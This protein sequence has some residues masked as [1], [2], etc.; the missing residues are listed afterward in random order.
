MKQLRGVDPLMYL[1]ALGLLVRNPAIMVV[2]LLMGVIGVFVSQFA[3]DPGGGM[4][5][6]LTGSITGFII[7]LLKLFAFGTATILADQAW[8]RPRVSFD[9]GWT[10]ARRKAGEIISAAFGFTFVLFIAGYAAQLLGPFGLV[11]Y[12]AAIFFL[13]YT[14]PAAAI[15]GVPGGAALQISIDRARAHPIP[16]IVVTVISVA[17]FLY[18]GVLLSPLLA[19]F[20]TPLSF[21]SFN[22]VAGLFNA[23]VQAIAVGYIALVVAKT[24]N[25]VSYGSRY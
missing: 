25:D 5:S 11:V 9:D 21:A 6:G 13:I 3:G 1:R 2:P 18:L 10:E 12:A 17:L 4:L 16:T 20:I 23:I 19:F 22:L 24:Y 15:G 8:R 14:I 7:L